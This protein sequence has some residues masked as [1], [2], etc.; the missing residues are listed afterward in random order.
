MRGAARLFTLHVALAGLG[1]AALSAALVLGLSGV[2]FSSP[3]SAALVGACRHWL[4]A[5]SV[6]GWIGVAILVLAATSAWRGL[7]SMLGDLAASRRYLGLLSIQGSRAVGRVRFQLIDEQE[8]LAFCAGFLRP[9]IYVSTG[10]LEQLDAAELLAVLTHEDH[11]HHRRDPLRILI[12]RALAAALFFV[13]VLR[14][15]SERFSNL[16]ELAADQAA[17][18]G[19]GSRGALASAMVKFSETAGTPATG[20]SADRVDHLAG[21]GEAAQWRL[22]PV[23]MSASLAALAA[24]VATVLLLAQSP[25]AAQIEIPLLF[26]QSCMLA[27]TVGP[28]LFAGWLAMCLHRRFAAG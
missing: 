27:M 22:S 6:G 1:L 9:R 7:R 5:L 16:E 25:S 17:L 28:A 12:G 18:R 11:H 20:I 3:S 23:V 24:L 8:P 2:S 21:E 15:S 10:T 4:P 14:F 26:A 19:A 13:P